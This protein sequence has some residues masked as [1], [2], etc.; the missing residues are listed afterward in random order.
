MLAQT[1]M[2]TS[3]EAQDYTIIINFQSGARA[4]HNK[5]QYPNVSTASIE[6][7]TTQ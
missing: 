5:N 2:D 6:A 1:S 3:I 7:K 4:H